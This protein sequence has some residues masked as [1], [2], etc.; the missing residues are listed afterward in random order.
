MLSGIQSISKFFTPRLKGSSYRL[1]TIY[2]RGK[3]QHEN[4][5]SYQALSKLRDQN[6]HQQGHR[7]PL[8]EKQSQGDITSAVL[9]P[10]RT[11]KK[12]SDKP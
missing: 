2:K 3:R 11:T 4:G 6:Y 7:M 8:D 5:E 10:K 12:P 1:P 9:M